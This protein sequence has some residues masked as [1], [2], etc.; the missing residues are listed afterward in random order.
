[1]KR[2]EILV[3]ACLSGALLAAC[4]GSHGA[5]SPGSIVTP[6]VTALGLSDEKILY[7]FHGG[8]DGRNPES[9][10]LDM[11][12]TLYGATE[13]GG[14]ASC[15]NGSPGCGTIFKIQ[16]SGAGYRVLHRYAQNGKE[17][18]LPIAGVIYA[19]GTL[20]GTTEWGGGM[21]CAVAGGCGTAFELDPSGIHYRVIHHF[22]G[23]DLSDGI[24]AGV[25]H[26]DGALYG[27]TAGNYDGTC[28]R[29]CGTL[30]EVN[31]GL[32]RTTT[33]HKFAQLGRNGNDPVFN[34]ID[35]NGALYG[36]TVIG[37][38]LSC[39]YPYGCGV[40]FKM[41]LSGK[42]YTVLHRFTGD[43]DGAFPNNLI[44]RNGFLYGTTSGGGSACGCG[45]VFKVNIPSGRESVLYRFQGG[46]DGM[47]PTS[48]LA[49]VNGT[50]Y[51]TTT[52]GGA[53][54]CNDFSYTGCGTVFEIKTSGTG[55]HVLYRFQGR[56]DGANPMRNGVIDVNGSLYGMTYF[57]G[58]SGC[59]GTG[60]GT[61]FRV[62]L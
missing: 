61:V 49:G 60:C 6:A 15:G 51:S 33:L 38:D 58:G 32:Q 18:D 3:G 48:L 43:Q 44:E 8:G 4:G 28:L 55:Y 46:S 23:T 39:D 11:G 45:T 22:S 29:R 42:R 14:Q 2:S 40:I 25:L 54:R 36:T 34:P 13:Y 1:M 30:F 12:G 35:V 62:R 21:G 52:F 20:Y 47:N 56:D 27:A 17:G 19:D 37:G 7:S 57:G 10:L 5:S 41:S 59:K 50:L 26:R 31:S 24:L 9:A 53:E 16:T